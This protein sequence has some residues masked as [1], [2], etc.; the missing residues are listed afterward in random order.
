MLTLM[1]L[2]MIFNDH[3]SRESLKTWCELIKDDIN[4]AFEF[5]ELN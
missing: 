2:I 4:E 1:Q 5:T 3:E